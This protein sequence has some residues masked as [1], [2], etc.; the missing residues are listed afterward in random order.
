M[1]STALGP[2]ADS[3]IVVSSNAN[4][5][6]FP[7]PFAYNASKGGIEQTVRTCAAERGKHGIRVNATAP[8]YMTNV[9][10]DAEAV[11]KRVDTDVKHQI[12][13]LTP[14][15]RTGS[16]DKFAGPAVLLAS[17]APG[18]VTGVVLPVD[19]GYTAL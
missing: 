4:I 19:G 15:A 5:V 6:A 13:A 14:L 18:F 12:D 10:R 9:V 11:G 16:D 2:P 8:G 17:D 1:R 3:I 7:N